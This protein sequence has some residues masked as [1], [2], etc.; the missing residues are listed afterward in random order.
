MRKKRV[1]LGMLLVLLLVLG[2]AIGGLWYLTSL[3]PVWAH[4]CLLF[5]CWGLSLLV[6]AVFLALLLLIS[7]LLFHF[8]LGRLEKVIRSAVALSFPFLLGL[9]RLFFLSKETL[10]ESFVAVNNHLVKNRQFALLPEKILLLLPHCLQQAVCPHKI[11]LD[12]KNC[13]Q[14][15]K[16][17]IG[18]LTAFCQAE[19][20]NLVVA[21][22]GTAARKR[23][24]ELRPKGVVAVACHRD[25][26]SG[27]QDC[28]PLPVLGILNER[29]EG[30]C[31]NTVVDIE[32]IK[33][34]VQ[35][36]LGNKE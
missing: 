10:E 27:I 14:C 16:C 8:P 25:L 21:T 32:K 12:S 19:G 1:Y 15:G 7:A 30:P 28:Y 23:I 24:K 5:F 4:N 11:T 3:P 18:T 33:K 34:A 17:P 31:Y 9:G 13:R 2:L 29:P 6:S 26:V 35:F 36:F 22:G 20:I